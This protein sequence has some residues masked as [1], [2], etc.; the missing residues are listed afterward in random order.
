[1]S[2][3]EIKYFTTEIV[4]FLNQTALDLFPAKK[5]DKHKLASKPKLQ[6]VLDDVKKLE[7]DDIYD[8]AVVLV[9]GITKTHAFVSGNRRTALLCV[10]T[11]LGVNKMEFANPVLSYDRNIFIGIREN[12]YKDQ[13]IKEWLK[14]GKIKKFKR[15]FN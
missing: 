5:G 14:N 10:I 8:K 13:E 11:F 3:N 15:S 6:Q 2:E 12:Y 7:T 1:M 4:T 9:K